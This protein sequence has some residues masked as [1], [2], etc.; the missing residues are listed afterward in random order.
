MM[1]DMETGYV[2]EP[3]P[4]EQPK[5]MWEPMDPFLMLLFFLVLWSG[6]DFKREL[7]ETVANKAKEVYA[8]GE[9]FVSEADK[10]ESDAE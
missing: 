2:S 3:I 9:Q 4:S 1:D 8:R 10:P 7:M 5:G 6:T